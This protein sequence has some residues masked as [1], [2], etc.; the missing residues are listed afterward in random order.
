MLEEAVD[1][2]HE[3]Y[4]EA[5]EIIQALFGGDYVNY[6]GKHYRVDS[7]KLYDLPAQPVR[8]GMAAFGPRAARLAARHADM[9]VSDQPLGGVADL[10]RRRQQRGELAQRAGAL[11]PH[12][13]VEQPG[14]VVEVAVDDRAADAGLARD[15]LDRD[16]VEAV[17][18]HDRLGDVEQL[19]APGF[20]GHAGGRS[21]GHRHAD[22]TEP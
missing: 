17:P 2:R 10:D 18:G 1:I 9:L 15:A 21:C 8:I 20:G 5:V 14:Q 12:E 13:R 4:E 3:M 7:A 16:G 11:A 22:V 6:H 19:L